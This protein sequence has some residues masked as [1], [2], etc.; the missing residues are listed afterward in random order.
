MA[1][2]YDFTIEQGTSQTVNFV[3][4]DSA[5]NP[6]DL[7]GFTARAQVRKT[8]ST[9]DY[10]ISLTTEDSGITLGGA[11]GTVVLHFTPA[12]TTPV[13][14]KSGVYD[15]ELVSSDGTVTRLVQGAV[16]FSPEATR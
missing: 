2:T 4:K 7:T 14:A 8:Y 3:W 6:V 15:V 9:A 10:L 16:D 13:T 12:K 11:A 5:G 1:A